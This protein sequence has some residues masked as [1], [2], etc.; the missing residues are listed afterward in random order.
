MHPERW[1]QISRLYH[2]ATQCDAGERAAFLDHVCLGDSSLRGELES[3]LAHG[4]SDAGLA[5]PDPLAQPLPSFVGRTV[6][7]Y[8]VQIDPRRR[9]HGSGVSRARHETESRR[10]AQDPSRAVRARRRSPR[11]LPARSTDPGVVEPSQ[12]RADL[13]RRRDARRVRA[14]AR[15]GRRAD[16]GRPHRPRSV[17]RCP[18]RSPSRAR[19]PTPC[20]PLTTAGSCI[21]I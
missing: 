7:A 11:P 10:R 8:Q 21:A 18:K 1:R 2:V 4:P 12:H 19:L 16:A 14:G 20:T 17:S 6:G 5:E 9:R 13:R 15:A 3:L